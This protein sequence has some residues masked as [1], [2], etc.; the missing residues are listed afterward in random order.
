MLDVK[1]PEII[2]AFYLGGSVQ[3]RTGD[4]YNVN[5]AL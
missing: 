1:K 4:L 2:R 5:V 3:I